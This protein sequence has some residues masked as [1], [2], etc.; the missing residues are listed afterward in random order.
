MT[1][2]ARVDLRTLLLPA[3]GFVLPLLG[4]FRGSEGW[5]WATPA[6]ALAV[7]FGG[8]FPQS[9]ETTGEGLV[10]RAGLRRIRIPYGE[11]REVIPSPDSRKNSLALAKERLMI[12]Y[13][14]KE[15]VISPQ[16]QDALILDIRMRAPH[17]VEVGSKLM[18]S[19][20]E[21][22]SFRS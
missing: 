20:A 11:I 3:V 1:Y 2:Q 16:E 15:V 4:M 8:Y 17:L 13:R 7:F 14:G 6:I 5:S 10:I 19:P 9:Y 12:R 18:G 22:V 21:A